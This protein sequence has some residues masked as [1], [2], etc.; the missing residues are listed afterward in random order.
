MQRNLLEE[1]NSL[2]VILSE[3]KDLYKEYGKEEIRDNGSCGQL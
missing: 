1:A 2:I 3:T